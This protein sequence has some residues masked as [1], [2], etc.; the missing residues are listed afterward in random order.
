MTKLLLIFIALFTLVM[1]AS[2]GIVKAFE[3]FNAQVCSNDKAKK[4]AAAC[5]TPVSDPIAGENGVLA[6][7]GNIVS[8]VAGA[9][10]VI[11]LVYGGIKYITSGG[12]PSKISSA[13]D[14]ILY[15]L[16]GLAIVVLARTLII[17]VVNKL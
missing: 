6:G 12:D 9:A 10:A 3:P 4:E 8:F 13:R 14:T 17:F 15:A 1:I 2:P 16:I 5:N 11:L 7:I